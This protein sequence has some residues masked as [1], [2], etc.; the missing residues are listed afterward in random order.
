MVDSS[1]WID[2]LRDRAE[3]PHVRWLRAAFG[4]EAILVGDLILLEVLQ[5]APDEPRA[6]KIER[7]L[8]EFSIEAMLN[9]ATA[10]EAALNYRT[11]RSKGVTVRKTIDLIIATFCIERDYALLHDDRDFEPM[12]RHLGLRVLAV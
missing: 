5:G 1:V 4:E 3:L 11:L 9:E 2:H 12:E 6:R 8:R 7:L 10:V